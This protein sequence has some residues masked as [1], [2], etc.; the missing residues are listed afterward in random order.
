MRI[1]LTSFAGSV[2]DELLKDVIQS[3]R[4]ALQ[5]LAQET[6]YAPAKLRQDVDFNVVLFCL[7]VDPQVLLPMAGRC[8]LVNFE[9][10]VSSQRGSYIQLLSQ[11][12][13]WEYSLANISK[14]DRMGIENFAYC[15]YGYVAGADSEVDFA[16]RL[17][18]ADRDI[19][20]FF[21]GAMRPRRR[22]LLDQMR[23]R[24][25]RVVSNDG[26]FGFSNEFRDA[27]LHRAKLVLNVHAYDDSR[28]VEVVRLGQLL[29][30]RK[31]VLTELYP[32]SEL[33]PALG[34]VVF[35]APYELLADTAQLLLAAPGI[36]E[37]KER[38]GLDAFKSLDF[39]E[40]VRHALQAYIQWRQDRV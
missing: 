22:K 37:Q 6:T 21:Y 10:L 31:A 28:I 11:H 18:D 3:F 33:D 29:R 8:V 20:V 2:M 35:G 40:S 27:Q 12:F 16:E 34:S 17:P 14:F 7:E 23:Q 1:H 15:P 4:C 26:D 13:V 30:R 25:L 19:D 9:Q 36:R 24:G 39:A 38:S 32:D 5:L